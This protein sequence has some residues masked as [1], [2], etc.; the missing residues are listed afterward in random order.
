ML[1]C[2]CL[3]GMCY[4]IF[5]LHKNVVFLS[6]TPCLNK[7]FLKTFC[8]SI[9][10]LITQYRRSWDVLVSLYTPPTPRLPLKQLGRESPSDFFLGKGAA[11]HWPCLVGSKEYVMCPYSDSPLGIVKWSQKEQPNNKVDT[12]YFDGPL[13]THSHTALVS[14]RVSLM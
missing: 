3:R 6:P 11:V 10:M 13:K 4:A 12:V 14:F 2:W 9:Y 8:Y 7:A 5:D 1:V